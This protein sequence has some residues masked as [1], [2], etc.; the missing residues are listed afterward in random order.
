MSK[1]V[2]WS[3]PKWIND[4][5]YYNLTTSKC[6]WLKWLSFIPS[7]NLVT[8]IVD[9]SWAK[10]HLET[11]S[12]MLE[13][14]FKFLEENSYPHLLSSFSQF[15]ANHEELNNIVERMIESQEFYNMKEVEQKTI[16]LK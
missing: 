15:K 1:L 11:I 2:K 7:S 4:S 5:K 8:E 16:E 14:A 13:N 9:E 6:C 12:K 3:S 10:S